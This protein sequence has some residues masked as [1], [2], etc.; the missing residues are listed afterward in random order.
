MRCAIEA[1]FKIFNMIN[2]IAAI[3]E[4]KRALGKD[5]ELLWKLPGDLKRLK[6]LTWGHPLIMG[7]K[8]LTEHMN[9]RVLDGRTSIV[10]S[11]DKDFT[12]PG[13][14]VVNSIEEA[15]EAAK[16]APGSEEVFIFG[17]AQIYALAL[18]HTQRL[19][20]TVVHDE[21]A[22]D[23]FFPDYSEFT[24]VI[25][26]EENVTPEGLHYDYVTLERPS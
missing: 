2:A 3:S 25:Q 4:T 14:I 26:K 21:P 19:Y 11:R 15:L 10:I 20:L 6:E 24:K 23:A 7:R 9:G 5:Q 22:A 18:P 17:G 16:K 13:V 12:H 8:T 1:K